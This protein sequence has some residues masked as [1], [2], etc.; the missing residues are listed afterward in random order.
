[1]HLFHTSHIHLSPHP[2]TFYI[3]T[4]R[5]PA[6]IKKRKFA[7]GAWKEEAF[8][9]STTDSSDSNGTQETT[10]SGVGDGNTM[11]V[12]QDTETPA[13]TAVVKELT[14]EEDET[15]ETPEKKQ[16]IGGGDDGGE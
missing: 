2:P 14:L 13:T 16:K 12:D 8:R 15:V 6:M 4:P 10:D 1:M 7:P 11:T 5:P 9:E 3:P